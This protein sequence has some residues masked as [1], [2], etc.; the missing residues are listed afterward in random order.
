MTENVELAKDR[1]D[2]LLRSEALLQSLLDDPKHGLGIKRAIKEKFPTARTPDVDLLDQVTKP[3]EEKLTSVQSALEK[4][5]KDFV[6]YRQSVQDREA[7]QDLRTKLDSIRYDF[8]FN[9]EGMAAVIDVMKTRNLAH[10]PEAAAL[11][12]QS[13][14]P[15]PQPMSV[16]NSMLGE[17]VDMFG[18]TNNDMDKKWERLHAKPWD[19]FDDQVVEVIDEFNRMAA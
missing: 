4:V 2:A 16:R 6:D 12:V 17:K 10:D 15:K 13:K 18:L 14:Q 11:I 3:F 19:F 1:A 7:E 5:S 9:D 8:S